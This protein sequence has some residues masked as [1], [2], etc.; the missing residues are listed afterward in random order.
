MYPELDHTLFV[1]SKKAIVYV[2]KI[3]TNNQKA[4]AAHT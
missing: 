3:N 4:K 2:K 1:M